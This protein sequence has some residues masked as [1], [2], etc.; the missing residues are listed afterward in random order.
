MYSVHDDEYSFHSTISLLRKGRDAYELSDSSFFSYAYP[1]GGFNPEMTFDN[2]FRSPFLVKVRVSLS[3]T[4]IT[5]L[6]YNWYCL[7]NFA[8]ILRDKSRE[9]RPSSRRFRAHESDEGYHYNAKHGGVC[10]YACESSFS[11]LR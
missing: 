10:C 8:D 9:R 2:V 11:T 3:H 5:M 7:D 6:T 4:L 1:P